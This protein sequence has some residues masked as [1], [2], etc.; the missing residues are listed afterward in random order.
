MTVYRSTRALRDYLISVD[1]AAK[2][3]YVDPN[4]ICTLAREGDIKLGR[5]KGPIASA[6]SWTA[7]RIK[8]RHPDPRAAFREP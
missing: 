5:R 8:I 3:I 6:M 7:M 2:L 1:E 4:R